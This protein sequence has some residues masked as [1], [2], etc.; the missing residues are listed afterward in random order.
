MPLQF[1]LVLLSVALIICRP[2]VPGPAITLVYLPTRALG[3]ARHRRIGST[4][5][6][7]VRGRLGGVSAGAALARGVG[8]PRRCRRGGGAS[9]VV[10]STARSHSR[11]SPA[12]G[13]AAEPEGFN[14]CTQPYFFVVYVRCVCV[15]VYVC[16]CFTVELER[17]RTRC[18]LRRFD[19]LAS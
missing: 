3:G 9:F 11:A 18:R 17:R 19:A 12:A 2:S 7:T 15:C 8:D 10:V 14:T 13:H 16:M 4:S 1:A 6:P 5:R